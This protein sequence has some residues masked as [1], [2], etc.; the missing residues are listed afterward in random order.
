MKNANITFAVARG[1]YSYG[2]VDVHAVQSLTNIKAAVLKVDTYMFPC[3][4]K[5]A[6]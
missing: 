6:T 3:R 1:Y 5:N 2:A 4:G